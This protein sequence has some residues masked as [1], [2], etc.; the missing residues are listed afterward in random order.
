M[1]NALQTVWIVDDDEIYKYG[2]RKFVAMKQL[3][4]NVVDFNNGRDAVDFLADPRNNES[5]PDVI[6]LDIDMPQMNGWD[7]IKAFEYVKI[8]LSRKISIFMVTSS[9]SYKDIV[10]VKNHSDI[11]EYIIKPVNSQQFSLVFSDV[12]NSQTP[13]HY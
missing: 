8:H 1:G 11:T 12:L 3:C 7:F 13:A 9:L 4:G 5:L 10:R 6:F 2:F